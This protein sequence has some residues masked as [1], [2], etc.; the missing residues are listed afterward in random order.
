MGWQA[1]IMGPTD[2]RQ[3]NRIPGSNVWPFRWNKGFGSRRHIITQGR[4]LYA[5]I[6]AYIL[7]IIT[8]MDMWLISPYIPYLTRNRDL[9]P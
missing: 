4:G 8:G 3:T 6:G 7:K 5:D 2:L 1:L 9:K